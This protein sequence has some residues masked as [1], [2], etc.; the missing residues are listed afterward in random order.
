[1]DRDRVLIAGGGIGGLAA[2]LGLAQKGIASLVLEK[3]A[4]LG[5][6]GAGIQ[7]GPNAFH[8]FDRLGVGEA[9]RAMAVYI[10]TLRL[11]DAMA[12]G[13]IT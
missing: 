10:D 4:Q 2:A 12:D 1:M 13:E 5:E 11:M 6:I 8:C 3:A 7:L 9:A